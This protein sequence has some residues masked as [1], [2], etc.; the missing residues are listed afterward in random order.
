MGKYDRLGEFLRSQKTR[1]VP[2]TFAEIE[3]VIGGKLPPNSPQYPAW[4]SNNPTNNVMTRV[5]LAAG[6]RTEQVDTRARKVV[7]RRTEQ[8]PSEALPQRTRKSGRHPLFG[9]LKGMVRIP[10]GVDLTEPADPDW[11]KVYE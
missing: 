10:P 2:M 7:F 4:W 9:A 6:F 8:K 5:W 11:G 1:E 3:R